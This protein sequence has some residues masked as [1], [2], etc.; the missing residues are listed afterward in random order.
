M[1]LTAFSA[2]ASEMVVCY[3]IWTCRGTVPVSMWCKRFSKNFP[4]PRL[5]PF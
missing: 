5:I 2:A 4:D 3:L 1:W